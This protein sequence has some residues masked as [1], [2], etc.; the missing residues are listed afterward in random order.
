MLGCG[1]VALPSTEQIAHIEYHSSVNL[2][3]VF[4]FKVYIPSIESF[5]KK[6]DGS[7][8]CSPFWGNNRQHRPVCAKMISFWVRKVLSIPKEY[9]SLGTLQGAVAS[10]ALVSGVSLVSILQA[11]DR[12]RVSTPVK[13]LFFTYITTTDRHQDSFQCVVLGLNE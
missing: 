7:W 9:M 6:L 13:I 4:Y 1:A 12:A 3:P 11:Y 8:V 10:A 5:T 2:C